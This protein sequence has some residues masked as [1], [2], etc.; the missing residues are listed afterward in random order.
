MYDLKDKLSNLSEK[1]RS[2]MIPTLH[3]KEKKRIGKYFTKN[4]ISPTGQSI[5][6]VNAWDANC[7]KTRG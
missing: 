2:D 4:C 5:T 6:E 1:I 7:M 3:E